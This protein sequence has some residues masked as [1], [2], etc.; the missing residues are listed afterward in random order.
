MNL[1]T[2]S[3]TRNQ[4]RAWRVANDMQLDDELTLALIEA[5]W[6]ETKFH[7]YANKRV[8]SSLKLAND[9][10]AQDHNSVGVMQQQVN[11]DG[12]SR[13]WGSVE[14]AMNPEVAMRSFGERAKA[15]NKRGQ[16][17]HKVAQNVQRSA[18][19]D[20]RNY[21]KYEAQAHDLIFRMSQ[22]CR[23]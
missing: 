2:D 1:A 8:A 19:S 16:G 4:W 20:G 14:Q 22:S 10:T 5:L 15:S 23:I 3:V 17:A 12:S 13:G 7:N 9:G 21:K 11:L 18:F 6:A